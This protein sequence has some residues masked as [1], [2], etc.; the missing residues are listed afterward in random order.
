MEGRDAFLEG[1]A[2]GE[3]FKV[4]STTHKRFHLFAEDKGGRILK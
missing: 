4:L 2:G 3:E 1:E